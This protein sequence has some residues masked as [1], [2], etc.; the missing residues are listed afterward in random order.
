MN[1]IKFKIKLRDGER[2][3]VSILTIKKIMENDT[4]IHPSMERTLK[5]LK[6]TRQPYIRLPIIKEMLLNLDQHVY[7]ERSIKPEN[8]PWVRWELDEHEIADYESDKDGF[9]KRVQEM[10]SKYLKSDFYD[11]ESVS[12]EEVQ[13]IDD[14]TNRTKKDKGKNIK[15]KQKV[16]RMK[17]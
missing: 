14:L 6:K 8:K 7:Y 9:I 3:D 5:L 2:P 15:N 4:Y 1:P 17:R 10:Y 16:I 13:V 12:P 11:A